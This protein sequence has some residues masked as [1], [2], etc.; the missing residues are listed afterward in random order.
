MYQNLESTKSSPCEQGQRRAESI[1]SVFVGRSRAICSRVRRACRSLRPT[2]RRGRRNPS[3][4]GEK[5]YRRKLQI[6][7][8][9]DIKIIRSIRDRQVRFPSP[10]STTNRA[11]IRLAPSIGRGAN[12][13][14]AIATPARGI[15]VGGGG[16]LRGEPAHG[17]GRMQDAL[18]I[19][20]S[21]R[22]RRRQVI[23]RPQKFA[24]DPRSRGMN[25]SVARLTSGWRESVS[26]PLTFESGESQPRAIARPVVSLVVVS[27]DF[28]RRRYKP[29]APLAARNL[30][31]SPRSFF[32]LPRP[33]IRRHHRR[34]I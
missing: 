17:V 24:T 21:L 33:A 19:F 16:E 26:R 4:A 34:A 7:Q 31:Q 28:F 3:A 18:H 25:L 13:R 27:A 29:R 22:G 32:R 15:V 11:S 1:E 23:P 14:I 2:C 20:D 10:I 5:I 8:R 30:R 9:T 12:D 6:R